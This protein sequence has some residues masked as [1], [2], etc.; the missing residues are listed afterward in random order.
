MG[1]CELLARIM[2]S[3]VCAVAFA[4]RMV[5]VTVALL[6]VALCAA[7]PVSAESVSDKEKPLYVGDF[8]RAMSSLM[9]SFYCPMTRV[10]NGP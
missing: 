4:R 8:D 5:P 10:C 1:N 3:K 2:I 7:L 6:S 9:V